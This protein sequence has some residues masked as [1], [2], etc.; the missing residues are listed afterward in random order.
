MGLKIRKDGEWVPISGV[1]A[2]G[3]AGP[4]GPAST[5]PGPPG[6]TGG[7]VAIASGAGS[8]STGSSS[9]V[10]IV[11]ATIDP[12]HS[13]SDIAVIATGIV[14]GAQGNNNNNRSTGSMRIVRGNT[15]IGSEITSSGHGNY[16]NAGAG[17]VFTQTFHDTN[18][19]GG[20][21]QT[22]KLQVRR[23]SNSGPGVKLGGSS[24][25]NNNTQGNARLLLIEVL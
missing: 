2:P 15:A 18:D 7:D 10:D 24:S 20:D 16:P 8:G 23:T 22:Y 21:A 13:G 12:I 4:P 11:T 6:P 19:H 25:N 3:P 14:Q 5:V 9:Y 17:E 1:G